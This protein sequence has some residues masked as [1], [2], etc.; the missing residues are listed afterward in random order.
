MAIDINGLTPS[1]NNGKARPSE[2]NKSASTKTTEVS[3]AGTA[4]V[5]E[6]ST[7]E[8]SVALSSTGKLMHKLEEKISQLPDVDQEKV[9][10][11]QSLIASGEYQIDAQSIAQKIINSD[12]L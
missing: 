2:A 10:H 1:N 5:N 6:A 9:A 11:Y 8:S 12:N 4:S 7:T 3:T